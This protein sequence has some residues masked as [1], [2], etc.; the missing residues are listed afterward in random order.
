MGGLGSFISIR[1]TIFF[2]TVEEY[3]S[4]GF[5]EVTLTTLLNHLE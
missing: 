5:E 1:R 4:T 3:L 2:L